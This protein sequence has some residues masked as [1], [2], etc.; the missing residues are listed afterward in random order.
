[1]RRRREAAP[2]FQQALSYRH[3]IEVVPDALV[4]WNPVTDR[5]VRRMK[6]KAGKDAEWSDRVVNDG[7]STTTYELEERARG[8]SQKSGKSSKKSGKSQKGPV[9]PPARFSMTTHLGMLTS[10]TV[11]N[12]LCPNCSG[13][14]FGTCQNR[15]NLVCAQPLASGRCQRRFAPCTAV[16]TVEKDTLYLAMTLDDW[17]FQDP[18][19]VLRY[20]IRLR[21]RKDTG[22]FWA[23][24]DERAAFTWPVGFFE[25][26]TTAVIVAADGSKRVVDIGVTQ[27]FRG[28]DDETLYMDYEF[29]SWEPGER[30]YYG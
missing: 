28:R 27:T 20:R 6:L 5:A 2:V 10:S 26:P 29:P 11:E 16:V 8:A 22:V 30:F 15:A 25:V 9:A 14:G 4:E 19:N 23:P 3:Y 13:G 18:G 24:G 7:I 1:M 12:V 17:E 21:I